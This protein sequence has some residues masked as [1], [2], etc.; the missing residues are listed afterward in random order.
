M[1][2]LMP[3][4]FETGIFGRPVLALGIVSP[5]EPDAA[6]KLSALL[7]RCAANNAAL[8]VCRIADDNAAVSLLEQAGFRRIERL[9]TLACDVPQSMHCPP[10]IAV[11]T[12]ADHPACLA[13]GRNSFSFDRFHADP[14]IPPAIASIIKQTWVHNALT[15]RADLSLVARELGEVIGFMFCRIASPNPHIDLMAVAMDRRRRGY[16]RRLVK[17]A[18]AHYAGR[19][20]R[21]IVATQE[22]NTPSLALYRGL[23]FDVV[24]AQFTYHL[25]W[26]AFRQ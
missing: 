8:V 18:L 9:L 20:K 7:K 10:G 14:Q 5:I 2:H 25:T 15:G 26:P 17:A 1:L 13:I 6:Q 23:G 22:R 21:L 11:P 4:P 19:H 12:L 24:A 16:G 3:L